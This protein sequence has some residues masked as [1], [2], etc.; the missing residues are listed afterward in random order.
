MNL[1]KWGLAALGFALTLAG[2][3]PAAADVVRLERSGPTYHMAACPHGNPFGTARCHAHVV[4]DARGNPF[5]GKT[6]GATPNVTPSGYGPSQLQTAYGLAS[7]SANNGAGK[8][9]AMGSPT[10]T[11]PSTEKVA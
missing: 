10:K 8:V 11:H 3:S 9:I 1:Y 5:I 6:D 7:A 2:A 4:T